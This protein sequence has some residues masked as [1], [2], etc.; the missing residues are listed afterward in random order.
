MV[1]STASALGCGARGLLSL[2]TIVVSGWVQAEASPTREGAYIL[3][4]RLDSTGETDPFSH[5]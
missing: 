3:A 4:M 5:E 1:V 2:V